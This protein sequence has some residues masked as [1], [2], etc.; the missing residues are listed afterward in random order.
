MAKQSTIVRESQKRAAELMEEVKRQSRPRR[1]PW[2]P[3]TIRDM[4]D[5]RRADLVEQAMERSAQLA[6]A[7][8][9][10]RDLALAE[11]RRQARPRRWPWQPPTAYDKLSVR[12]DRALSLAT[13]RASALSE[14]AQ[15]R[16]DQLMAEAR[17]QARPRR[18]PWQPPTAYDKLS[19]QRDRALS[20]ATERAHTL[21]EAAQAHASDLQGKLSAAV[22]VIQ[23]Q[24][25]HLVAEARR[26]ARPRRW[27]W[28]PPTAYDKLSVQRAHA[29]GLASEQAS[30]L[31]ERA[32][33]LGEAAQAHAS[34]LQGKLTAAVPVIQ[35]RAAKASHRARKRAQAAADVVQQQLSAAPAHLSSAAESLRESAGSVATSARTAALAPVGA[36]RDQVSAGQHALSEGVHA[37]RRRVRRGLRVGRL[38]IWATLVGGILALLFAPRS[39]DETRRNIAGLW[40][41]ISR[42]LAPSAA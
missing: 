5:E 9:E 16:R 12:R 1:W 29:L 36:V 4:L 38:L 24:R 35:D 14:A 27:P 25:D 20:L 13:E 39:G 41:N 3:K 10:Q 42:S 8:S 2:Q 17:R 28:Q 40:Q 31:G 22:P 6:Q 11:A 15:A 30:I 33:T 26:Q 23:A 21:S 7:A 34:D 18:W 37:G 19:V 32:H